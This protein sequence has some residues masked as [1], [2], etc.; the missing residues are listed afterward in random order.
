MIGNTNLM[1]RS[2]Y[3]DFNIESELK[4][5]RW[6]SEVRVLF[7][8]NVID[9]EACYVEYLLTLKFCYAY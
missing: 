2:K 8:L 1:N 7:L 3:L 6:I 5:I 4:Y 9:D